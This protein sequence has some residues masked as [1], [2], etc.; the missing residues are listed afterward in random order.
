MAKQTATATTATATATAVSFGP[1]YGL[2]P[3][4]MSIVRGAPVN[5]RRTTL[6]GEQVETG[7]VSRTIGRIVARIGLF[8]GGV[9]HGTPYTVT[10]TVAALG[11]VP[12]KEGKADRSAKMTPI[13]IRASYGWAGGG[14]GLPRQI[15]LPDSSEL[16]QEACDRLAEA[17]RTWYTGLTPA[18]KEGA[19]EQGRAKVDR[20]PTV[21]LSPEL[22]DL[23]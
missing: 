23:L 5:P 3:E 17:W 14:A 18:Q 15:L 20:N 7:E 16:S 13:G 11:R 21:A 1:L 22:A 12:V 4:R 10:V 19:T 2:Q 9:W 6:R 8:L